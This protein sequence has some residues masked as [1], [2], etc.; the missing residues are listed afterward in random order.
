MTESTKEVSNKIFTIANLVSLIRL[1]LVPAYFV[2]LLNGHD[3]LATLLFAIAAYTDWIDGQIAR[4]T[5]TVTR[6]GQLLDPAVDRILVISCVI[7]LLIVGRLPI[8][9]F[10]IICLRDL[11]ML[12]G[13][14]V[15]LKHFNIRID[16]I[17]AGKV[18]T[19]LLFVGFVG[20]LL[21]WPLIEG[22]G[23]TTLAWLPGF[24]GEPYSWG[25]WFVYAGAILAY[26]VGVY[27]A[28]LSGKKLRKSKRAVE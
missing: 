1:C 18:A 20:L 6:L 15:L 23:V 12:L 26:I 19:T 4:R 10:V 24:N 27:Y 5:N 16:V 14:A 28:I 25:I 3:F 9:I 8:W 22:L 11:L 17:F 2:L 7:A 21:N 13:G